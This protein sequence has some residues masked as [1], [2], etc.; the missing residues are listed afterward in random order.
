[1]M[2]TL[3]KKRHALT[4]GW[5]PLCLIFPACRSSKIHFLSAPNTSDMRND[6]GIRA[7]GRE[8][9]MRAGKRSNC[10]KRK[11]RQTFPSRLY[12][13]SYALSDGL[14]N[15]HRTRSCNQARVLGSTAN[16]SRKKLECFLIYSMTDLTARP[17]C[18]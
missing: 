4:E 10:Q 16:S 18:I 7:E 8:R 17:R 9:Q 11:N 1:M 12:L 5:G 14:S 2:A 6:D 3:V 13:P 15:S